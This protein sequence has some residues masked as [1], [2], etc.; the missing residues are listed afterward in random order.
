MVAAV[1]SAP[2]AAICSFAMTGW[3]HTDASIASVAR[4][5]WAPQLAGLTF[6]SVDGRFHHRGAAWRALAVAPLGS[7]RELYLDFEPYMS[8][9][10]AAHLM[11]APWLGGLQRLRLSGLSRG[12]FEVLEAS[13]TFLRLQASHWVDVSDVEAEQAAGAPAVGAAG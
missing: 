1:A 3:R 9:G 7:L 8:A 4:A 5:C 11:S 13:P 10:V 2:L 6:T 12:A